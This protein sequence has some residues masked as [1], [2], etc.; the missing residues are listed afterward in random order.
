[1]TTKP[2][3]VELAL[4]SCLRYE[5]AAVKYADAKR[6]WG[7]TEKVKQIIRNWTISRMDDIKDRFDG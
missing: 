2:D 3:S 5:E 1:M 7:S 6:R 4:F